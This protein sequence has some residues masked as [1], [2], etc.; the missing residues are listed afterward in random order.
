MDLHF[1]LLFITR[2][3]QCIEIF[4]CDVI[5][6]PDSRRYFV[7]LLSFDNNDRKKYVHNNNKA[8]DKKTLKKKKNTEQRVLW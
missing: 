1:L 5:D 2:S 8:F 4:H 7:S 3:K 6:C